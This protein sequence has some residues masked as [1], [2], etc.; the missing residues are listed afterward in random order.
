MYFRDLKKEL[1][2]DCRTVFV[3]IASGT[4]FAYDFAY[5][6]S[7]RGRWYPSADC[8]VRVR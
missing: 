6:V 7:A 3:R 4:V 1:P 8:E 5:Y 2:K